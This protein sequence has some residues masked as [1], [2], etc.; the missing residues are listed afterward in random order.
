MWQ[1]HSHDIASNYGSPFFL[2]ETFYFQI[3]IFQYSLTNRQRVSHSSE[4]TGRNEQKDEK[5][6]LRR[7]LILEK[8]FLN[9][10]SLLFNL[11][12]ERVSHW[13]DS[14][15]WNVRMDVHWTF[16]SPKRTACDSQWMRQFR[17]IWSYLHEFPAHLQ[18]ETFLAILTICPKS[19]ERT[20]QIV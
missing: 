11:W 15:W 8:L 12:M 9:L 3:A 20:V 18:G 16:Y 4:P 6:T 13:Q 1:Y 2:T 14:K 7:C 17:T 19:E 5:S 10:E